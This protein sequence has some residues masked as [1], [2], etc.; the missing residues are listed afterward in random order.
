MKNTFS[1]IHSLFLYILV[2]FL[3]NGVQAQTNTNFIEP[4]MKYIPSTNFEMGIADSLIPD[5]PSANNISDMTPEKDV[6]PNHTVILNDFYIGIY[7]VTIKEYMLFAKESDSHYPEWLEVSYE[8]M[9]YDYEL[10]S[11]PDSF[12][13]VGISWEDASAYCKWLSQKSNKNYRLPTEAEWEYAARTGSI[14]GNKLNSMD[15]SLTVTVPDLHLYANYSDPNNKDQHK[16]K[17]AVG[18]FLPS[19]F[20]LY[21]IIGNVWEWCADWYNSDYYKNSPKNN[22]TGPSSGKYKVTRGG[23]YICSYLSITNR[24]FVPP[25][26]RSKNVGFRI[27]RTP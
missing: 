14:N 3:Y 10:V 17:S 24:N 11:Q 15:T 9:E 5:L 13:I 6:T 19:K 2:T 23:S 8:A 1:F 27:A 25:T 20:G 21:D 22:P 16:E 12:P 26:Y 18:T 7:E 4:K